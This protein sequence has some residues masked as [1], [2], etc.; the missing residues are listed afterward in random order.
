MG[1]LLPTIVLRKGLGAHGNRG[2]KEKRKQL[3]PR[4]GFAGSCSTL[5]AP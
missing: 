2:W 5:P 4:K 3:H 1:V